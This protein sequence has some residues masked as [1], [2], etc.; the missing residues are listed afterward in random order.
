VRPA[1]VVGVNSLGKMSDMIETK[2]SRRTLRSLGAVLA[3][4]L[5]I[6]I[7]SIA[8]DS[9]M[10]GTGVFPPLGAPMSD[11]LFLLATAYRIIYSVAGCYVAARFAPDRPMR[12]ALALGVVGVAVS[13]AG[14]AATWNRGPAFGPHWYPLALIALA[15]PCAWLGGKLHGGR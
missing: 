12:H 8:T 9:A 6:V 5:A 4:F 3:G 2:R 10:H 7:F 1:A 13:A 15:M 11:A 14:A